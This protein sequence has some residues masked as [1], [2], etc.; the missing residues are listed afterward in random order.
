MQKNHPKSNAL[1]QT[2]IC[3]AAAAMVT[4]AALPGYAMATTPWDETRDQRVTALTN[5][6]GGPI[7]L[8]VKAQLENET[9][10]INVNRY[11]SF[12]EQ[13]GAA[14]TESSDAE[15]LMA[16]RKVAERIGIEDAR[17]KAVAGGNDPNKGWHGPYQQL[18]A[19]L[20]ANVDAIDNTGKIADG[21]SE[22]RA[23]NT[24]VEKNAIDAIVNPAITDADKARKN[25]E[26]LNR[27]VAALNGVTS[28]DEFKHLT[29][30]TF[31]LDVTADNAHVNGNKVISWGDANL[32]TFDVETGSG[33]G[34]ARTK[35]VQGATLEI[36]S[37][38]GET[39]DAIHG[40]VSGTPKTATIGTLRALDGAKHNVLVNE[41]AL[42]I[43]GSIEGNGELSV[44]L[45]KSGVLNFKDQTDGA[46]GGIK[47]DNVTLVAGSADVAIASGN[48]AEGA[49]I[50]FGDKTS[51]GKAKIALHS[52][53]SLEFGK[54]ADAG[55]SEIVVA[56]AVTDNDIAAR[57][58]ER[59]AAISAD[60][61]AD[62][63]ALPALTK[64]L[65]ATI[66]FDEASAGN[67]NI[68]N[69]D[70]VAFKGS[71][72]SEAML[73]NL[74]GATLTIEG[75]EIVVTD[76]SGSAVI[77]PATN[78]PKTEMRSSDGGNALVY[79]Q[80]KLT[81]ENT[82]LNEA[83][84]HSTGKTV[85]SESNGGRATVA[86]WLGG[87]LEIGESHLQKMTLANAGKAVIS[88]SV[89]GEAL[90]A[91]LKDGDLTF[92]DTKLQRLS[93][94]NEGKVQLKG[95]TIATLAS[96]ELHGGLLDV[97][98]IAIDEAAAGA[99]KPK[100]S[101]TIGSLTGKGDVVTGDTVLMLGELGQDDHFEGK[102]SHA[103]VQPSAQNYPN[104]LST[105]VPTAQTAGSTVVK[106]GAGNL[107]LSGDQSGVKSL[108][109]QGGVLTA[110]HAN[111]LGS[112]AVNVA[113]AGTIAL[114]ANVSGVEGLQN[115]GTLDL[116]MNKLE[117]GT[118]ASEAGAK[119][120]SRLEKVEGKLAG[121][122]IHVSKDSDFTNTELVVNAANDIEIQ[123]VVGKFEVVQADG[124]AKVIGGEVKVGSITGGKK[125]DPIITTPEEPTTEPGTK[126]TEGNIVNFLAADGGYTANER[127][128]LASVD[129]VTVGELTSGAVGGKVLSAMALQTAGSDE[130]RKSAR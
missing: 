106:T 10:L 57:E 87:E 56:R 70:T 53:A 25:V 18:I 46:E 29:G 68:T 49:K 20:K 24:L 63:S 94:K 103:A 99:G 74:A 84:L 121:G 15:K 92:A 116:G 44:T 82:N 55:S 28:E 40:I 41:G 119:I 48:V 47:G 85:I 118:Y 110:A 30:N 78:S 65:G 114:S 80:G 96:I 69:A 32:K 113:K 112:G 111:A 72:L 37:F 34:A 66:E 95:E 23:L 3:M 125:P 86:N 31:L 39:S 89:G 21:A 8:A 77:N 5:A 76:S 4:A 9:K 26:L 58:A 16:L 1:R 128:V 97:S 123:D 104:A 117:V 27:K 83:V 50:T 2:K 12:A 100:D 54:G 98:E 13:V 60:P 11:K 73:K 45:G 42:D 22:R 43:H 61:T 52:G 129:G 91:N 81:V 120:K 101:L 108:S 38:S 19:D 127:A 122:K 33:N 79:N 59:L 90:I 88:K 126:I 51:A 7:D 75:K 6:N 71:D 35:I 130:Q 93:L 124:D 62:L 115:N 17:L 14:V 105:T 36:G 64:Q 67:A 107:T 102:I 109:V